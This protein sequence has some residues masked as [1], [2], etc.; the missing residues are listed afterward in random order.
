M[1]FTKMIGSTLGKPSLPGALIFDASRSGAKIRDLPGERLEFA[2]TYPFLFPDATVR[3]QFLN[4]VTDSPAREL[5]GEIPAAFPTVLG[6]VKMLPV[7]IGK[8][9][10][11]ALVTGGINDISPEN[12]INPLLYTGRYIERY[13]G[14]IRRVVEDNVTSLLQAVRT[15]CPNAVVFYFGFYSA[16]SYQSDPNKLRDL[17]KHEYNDDFKWWFNRYIYEMVNVNKM[18]N[19]AQTRSEWFHGRWQYWTRRAINYMNADDIRRGPGVIFV[20]SRF[21]SSQA[22]FTQ[23]SNLW[24]DYDFP[25]KDPAAAKRARLTPR[26]DERRNMQELIKLVILGGIWDGAEAR[27]RKEAAKLNAAINGPLTLKRNLTDFINGQNDAGT[28]LLE[29]LSNEVHRI[30]HALIASMAHP[31]ERGT[32]RY[33]TEAVRKHFEH[34]AVRAKV[35]AETRGH[36]PVG[37]PGPLDHLLTRCNLRT[38]GRALAADITHLEID[39]MTL[40][41]K[42]APNSAR[43]LGMSA[44]LGLVLAD[45]AGGGTMTRSFL[46]TFVNYVNA[47]DVAAYDAD[48]IGKPHPYLEP[49]TTNRL[50]TVTTSDKPIKLEDV[51][52]A[53][54]ALGPDPWPTASAKIRRRYGRTWAPD[55]ITLEVN[56]VRVK[57]VELFGSNFGPNSQIDLGWPEA[58]DREFFKPVARMHKVRRVRPLGKLQANPRLPG[59][60]AL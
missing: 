26:S 58:V 23:S 60:R 37:P 50:T 54:L 4:G 6:Q 30:Q 10:D 55:S 34:E 31:N 46:L 15:R 43:N 19:E 24:D 17:F 49:G 25:T 33:A 52:G 42:T 45:R 20:P 16:A 27:A 13:D 8:R 35:A 41:V 9:I 1:R 56:G 57:T 7:N 18:I 21:S 12:V 36:R 22:G 14:E 29:S 44:S 38:V 48:P 28:L 51:I 53:Y 59:R 11:I 39:A 5:Y 32:L 2:D 40:I 3:R 47:V